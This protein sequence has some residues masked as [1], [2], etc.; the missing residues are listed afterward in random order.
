V[1]TGSPGGG[2]YFMATGTAVA[3]AVN[4]SVIATAVA[5]LEHDLICQVPPQHDC[6][7]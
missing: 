5:V 6:M 1:V 2:G 4:S 3:Q 7:Q